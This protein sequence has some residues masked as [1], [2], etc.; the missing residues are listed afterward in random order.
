MLL[1]Y[2]QLTQIVATYIA[3]NKI[4]VDSP[5]QPTVDNIAGLVD[6]I[7][8]T[9]MLDGLYADKLAFM[10]GEDLPL[11]KTI[12]EYYEDLVAPTDYDSEG[13][14]ALAPNNPTYRKPS[15]SYTLGEKT[16]PT[17]E[18][19]NNLE[20]ACNSEA[21]YTDMVSKIT[22]KLWDSFTAFKYSCKRNILA[23]LASKAITEQTAS[24]VYNNATEY[25]VNTCLKESGDSEVRGIVVKKITSAVYA[26]VNTWALAVSGGYIVPLNLVTSLAVPTDEATG[27]AFITDVKKDVEIASDLSEG[28][29][30]NGNALGVAEAGYVL[31]V[32]QGVMPDIDTKVMAGAFHMEKV[33]M[34]AE[35]VVIKDFGNDTN[36]VFAMLVDRRIAR[37]H[38]GYRAVR[39]QINAKGDFMN[40][41]L[42]TENTAFVSKNTF[43]KVYKSA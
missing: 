41:F 24:T 13:T 23:D 32:K 27:E 40:Y 17:S 26:T 38:N 21:E 4:A 6:K 8:K 36:G 20:R 25:E 2:S 31:I 14:N 39:N 11:G 34:P 3:D 18:R 19:Y 30:L 43:V 10:D 28:H 15:Y 35:V 5:F 9:F 16:F 37:F 12:E 22:K 33:A 7:S 42:H 29:S 1:T